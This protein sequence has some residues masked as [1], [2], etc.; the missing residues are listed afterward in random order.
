[1]G[2][3]HRPS[4]VKL[5]C[6]FIFGDDNTVLRT[7]RL[8]VRRFGPLDLT[9]SVMPFCHTRYYER[10]FGTD[11]KRQF[12]SFQ[13]LIW[14]HQLAAIK[15]A[16]MTIERTLSCAGRRQVNID[17]GY[18]DLAKLVLAST[19]DYAH[20]IYLGQGIYAEI[21]LF[22]RAGSFRAGE[23][24]YADY[25]TEAYRQIF[26]RIRTLYAAQLKAI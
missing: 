15:R 8:L 22:Y 13:R 10:E 21:T 6:G 11:L 5:I 3:L 4:P 17:P 26:G 2:Q 16:T 19:K 25:C 14:P 18:L 7:Q 12:V 1:M 24:T 9:S 20:R 23:W